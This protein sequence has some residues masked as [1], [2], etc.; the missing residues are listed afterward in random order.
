MH[1]CAW[2][3]HHLSLH[4][5]RQVL[6]LHHGNHVSQSH[7][8]GMDALEHSLRIHTGDIVSSSPPSMTWEA[9]WSPWSHICTWMVD[10]I[11]YCHPKPCLFD[12]INQENTKKLN[13]SK[14]FKRVRVE[15]RYLCLHMLTLVVM[16]CPSLPRI[17]SLHKGI[18]LWR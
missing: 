18:P 3:T 15:I 9:L 12:S 17:L 6:D 13:T 11:M 5:L 1:P 8:V 7:E 10:V 2:Y 16:A 4:S 14:F